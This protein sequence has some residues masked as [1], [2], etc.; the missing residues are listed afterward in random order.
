MILT[1]STLLSR[2]N[3]LNVLNFVFN[4]SFYFVFLVVWKFQYNDAVSLA[5]P[6]RIDDPI[7]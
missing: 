5:F 1:A 3:Y 2:R 7:F 6:G 4:C